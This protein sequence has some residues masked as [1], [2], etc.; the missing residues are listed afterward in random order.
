MT[1]AVREPK[2]DLRQLIAAVQRRKGDHLYGL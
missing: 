2:Y 1:Q